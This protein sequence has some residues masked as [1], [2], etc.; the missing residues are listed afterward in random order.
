LRVETVTRRASTGRREEPPSN[1]SSGLRARLVAVWSAPGSVGRTTTALN[2]AACASANARVLFVDLDFVSPSVA[3]LA[4]DQEMPSLSTV[5]H[6]HQVSAQI[7]DTFLR[8]FAPRFAGS[9]TA[10]RVIAGLSRPERWP[11]IE[12][13]AL[14]ALIQGLSP[15]V[16]LIICDLH[17]SAHKL[18]GANAVARSILAQANIVVALANAN[19]LSLSR[20]LREI[21]EMQALRSDEKSIQV[22]FNRLGAK[23]NQSPEVAAFVELTK[24]PPPMTIRDDHDVFE[25]LMRRASLKSTRRRRSA[26]K[27]DMQAL[28]D[29]VLGL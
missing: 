9:H 17:A 13:R 3:L 23:A 22:V 19:P 6:N 5:L 29:K 12:P 10:F 21:H 20:L 18:A 24:M 27:T 1:Q 15:H 4:A 25:L 14:E 26:Y 2:L 7:D 16:D 8:E 28:T 11:E